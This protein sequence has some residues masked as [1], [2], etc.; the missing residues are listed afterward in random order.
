MKQ[1]V[2]LLAAFLMAFSVMVIG[3]TKLVEKVTKTG[4][5]LV[6]PY[7][8]YE[9]AN[10]L[11]LI[12]H[13][14][15]SDPVVHVDVTYHVGSAREEI[16][17]SGFAHFFEH[18][19]F[20]GSDNVADEQ[21]F[22]IVSDAG[23]TLNGTT[24][25]DRTNYFETVPSNQLEKML[26][27]EADRMG[28]LLDAV[29]QKKFEI[30]R[31]TVKNE[32]GQNYDNRPYGLAGETASKNLYPYGHPYSWLTIGYVEDLNRVNVDDLKNFFLRWYGPNNATV[33][34]GGDVKP[35][36]VVKLVE[37][38]FGVI[39][40]GPEVK[41]V[42][43]PPVVLESDRYASYT[44]NYAK[45]PLLMVSYP[46]VPNYH[47]DM[48]A[49]ACLAQVLGQGK[50]SILY[51]QLVKKQ[52]ALQAS[53]FSQL[54]ELSGEMMFQIV[55]SPGK[56]L[57]M[58]DSL[59]R[60]SLDSFEAKGVTDDDI[61]KFKGGIE[62]Q[63]INGLQS[64][65]GKISQ[66][67]SFQTFTGNPNKIAD[68]IKMYQAVT[69]EDVMRVYNE[70]VKGKHAVFLSVVPKGQEKMIAA[71][72]N[73]KIDSSKYTA[74]DYGY[75]GLK[76]IKAKDNFDRR[77]TPGNGANPI[78]KVPKFWRKDMPNGVRMIGTESNETPTVTLTITV[79][80]GHILQTNDTAKIGL[81]SLF[82]SM[83]NEDT[84][85]YT[86]EQMA[87]EL[88]KL[89]SN[90]SV[91]SNFDGITF[92][93]QTLKKN[94]DKT[95]ALVQERM[96]NPKFTEAAFSR[97]QKQR[98][99]GFKQTK[100][101]PAAVANEVF[102]KINYGP[103]NILSMSEDGTEYTIG[104]LKL[105]DIE[106]YYNNYM[107][108]K[109]V[110]VVIVG[111]VKQEEILP[112][113]A[114]L[115]KLPNKKIDL[116]KV[117]G[118]ASNVDKTK[119]YMV[120]IPK[121]AQSQFR[122]GYATDLKYDATGDYYKSRLMNYTLGGDFNS[123]LNLN[124]REDKGWTYGARSSFT[125]DEYSSDFEFSSGIRADATDSAL[126]EVMKELKNYRENGITEAE[127]K[128]MKNSLGQRDAL[129]YETGIQKAGFIGRILDYNLPANYVDQQNKILANL[130]KQQIDAVAKKMLNPDK[131]NILLV[132]DKAKILEG[133][134]KL[135][136][137]IIELDVDGKKIEKKGF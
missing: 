3:Q 28:F 56:S 58:L 102:A 20:Q 106:N 19:M 18:M 60:N 21:H 42:Q 36:D 12:V 76:Y 10:G 63:Q 8:K 47:K 77:K 82:S 92:N 38:Y 22:K 73:Y 128:F 48:G 111:D 34:V 75:A 37:K 68:L 124:L 5:E 121:A 13:E 9:L 125:A 45:L 27:L 39:P 83:M 86:A 107:T 135:G 112:K 131:M 100:A 71:A 41:P 80:G 123:R 11:T 127:L 67:A 104:N 4:N 66:L 59:F 109:G 26:W 136:Y 132:G 99:Q 40:R 105:Q 114:F 88:Q 78:V 116:P 64:V 110:K 81:A 51:Q 103:N 117:K 62:A 85:N 35:A 23:G 31:S 120:D 93:I 108:S 55:P 24:N 115:N 130:T 134:K 126:V 94:L 74:P 16:G 54:S 29:T 122:V 17:K 44:D 57:A 14:D 129:L 89:G 84:K 91:G 25:R 119:V 1:R 2:L 53:V 52:L 72:D 98:L 7:E 137:E 15:H 96:F 113:L 65:S 133:V 50:N 69:K 118:T 90:V 97:I 95:L 101:D 79:P 70:Y 49:L 46:T 6:I 43:V 61:A 32:R 33:S 30:Q 87:V